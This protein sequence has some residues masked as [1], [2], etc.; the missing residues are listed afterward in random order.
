LAVA[1]YH[2]EYGRYPPPYLNGPDGRPWHSWRVLILPY[3]EYSNLHQAYSFAEPWDGPNNRK[4]AERMP[5]IFAFHGSERAENTTTNYLAVVGHE[6]AWPETKSL[7]SAEVTDGL[8]STI[9]LV[10]NMGAAV[11]W[12]EPRDLLLADMDLRVNSPAGVS[13][14]Y[15]DSAVA[16]LDGNLHRLRPGLKPAVLR[17]LLTIRGGE[18][19]E[20]DAAGAWEL[21]PDG[22]QRL[23]RDD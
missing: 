23:R 20:V 8:D 12:M 19:L 3:I 18:I 14:P 21:L 4:L 13:S 6:T 17:G 22:R 15:D 2:H 5:R 7:T 1:N 16:M 11:H 9:L 10:E